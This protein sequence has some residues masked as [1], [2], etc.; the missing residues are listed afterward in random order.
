MRRRMRNELLKNAAGQFDL[1]QGVGGIVDIEF[2]VQFA[3]L[4]W[5]QTQPALTTFTDTI[6]LLEGLAQSG[7]MSAAQVATLSEA[8]QQYRGRLHRLALQEQ[9][10]LV[11]DS[12]FAGLREAV[13]RIWHEWMET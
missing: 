10:R 4:A 7:L 6:R 8:Y 3:V 2:M 13:S 9:G 11:A 1:K 12:E 5:A